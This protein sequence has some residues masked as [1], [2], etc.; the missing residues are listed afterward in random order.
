[1]KLFSSHFSW[2][3]SS[4]ED[5]AIHI[6]GGDWGKDPEFS[7]EGYESVSCIRGSEFK[8]WKKNFGNTAVIRKVKV[9]SL[10][11]RKLLKN[12]ILV[13]I[14]GGGPDQPVGRTV[15][16]DDRV[17]NNQTLPLVCTNFV[18]LVRLSS[19]VSASFINRYLEFFYSSGEVT[20]Y[21]GGSNNLRNLKFKD[22][23]K[24][25]IPLPSLAEQKIIAEKLDTLLAQ[26]DTTK[27]RLEQIPQILKCFRQ[28]VLTMAVRGDLTKN[29]RDKNNILVD[30]WANQKASDICTKVQSG[31]TPTDNPFEQNGKI[32][33]LKVYNI[34]N[35]KIDFDYKPQF[36]TGEVHRSKSKRSIAFPDDVLMNIVGPPLGKVA[37]LTDQYPE[38]NLNQAITLFRVE[39][40]KILSKFLY[41]VLCEGKL[42]RDVMHDTKGI[43]GQ[44]NISLTQCREAV[45]P[46][47]SLSEQYEIVRRV[48]QLFAYADTIEKQVNNAL[49][50]VNNLTQSILAKAFRGE[51]TAQWRAENP[52]LI[53]GENSAAALLEKIKAERAASGSKKVS[54]K[55]K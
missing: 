17:L 1:M 41:Y 40:E 32:P 48:E 34:V 14:S 21:Q 55:K 13:E 42:V 12:D 44:I 31:S 54:R 39:K 52:D 33:F 6:I 35:Q 22:Y 25:E 9:S 7:E 10:T 46:R 51:L 45:I 27:A 28:A 23:S 50:R 5:I 2:S 49:V 43:V 8:N 19:E 30:S 15:L 24:I 36:I 4:L 29:W 18:R 3:K 20:K 38:W 16:I 47:P 53:S 11:S 37:I 26:V